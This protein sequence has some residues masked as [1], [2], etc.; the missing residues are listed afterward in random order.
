MST[1]A[2]PSA[3]AVAG[4]IG[5]GT[6]AL[7][8]WAV[9]VLTL[10]DLTGSDPAGNA[11]AQAYATIELVAVWLLL[12]ALAALAATKGTFARPAGIA[13]LVLIPVSG[14]AAVLALGLLS[15]PKLAPYRWPIIIPALVPPLVIAFC[16][17]VLLPRWRA[18][19]SDRRAIAIAWG[20]ALVLSLAIVPMVLLRDQAEKRL[21]ALEEKQEAEFA[22]L[23]TAPALWDLTPFLIA[24]SAIKRAEALERARQLDRRQSDAEVMLERGDFP[25]LYLGSLDLTP[26]PSLCDK[27]RGLLRRR[28]EPLVL[29]EAN[30]KNYKEIV[31]PVTGA[32][33]A[34]EWLVGYGCAAD[35]EAQAWEAVAKT[36]SDPGYE[37]Y[38]L[39]DLRDPNRLGRVL[40]EDPARFSMLTPQAHLKAWLKFAD[41][42]ALRGEA[43]AGARKGERR[44]AD[45]IEMLGS[46]QDAWTV[47]RYLPALDLE[48]TPALCQAASVELRKQFGKIYRPAADDPRPY[49]ELLARLGTGEQFKALIWL[50]SHGCE[51]NAP[52][53]EADALIRSYQNSS[54]REAM[55]SSLAQARR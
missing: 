2:K 20:G 13:A 47:I 10:A 14:L 32:V 34:M 12:G 54:E 19:I 40:R 5:L 21:I 42:K 48:P 16:L 55:L 6:L 30:A 38:R 24:P 7:A 51:K 22:N 8:I 18:A 26:T 25:L 3:F 50:A 27:A 17:W 4:A 49:S 11:I 23:P 46:E 36:Y 37:I 33:A 31:E 41:D 29:K 35:A 52:L 53:E 9:M 15:E 45:A 1:A 43:L 44:T 39:R 28:L